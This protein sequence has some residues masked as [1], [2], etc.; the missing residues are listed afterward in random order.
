MV[1]ML[2]NDGYFGLE[3]IVAG[4]ETFVVLKIIPSQKEPQ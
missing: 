2:F 1:E 3:P 4:N